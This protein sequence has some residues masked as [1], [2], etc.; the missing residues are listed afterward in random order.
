MRCSITYEIRISQRFSRDWPIDQSPTLYRKNGAE[1]LCTES[2]S[3]TAAVLTVVGARV[4]HTVHGDGL[5]RGLAVLNNE[6]YVLR[7]RAV[8]ALGLHRISALAPANPKSGHFSQIRL[9]PNF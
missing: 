7:G 4:I 5:V 2:C 9:R 1:Q 6:L 8:Q 3:C